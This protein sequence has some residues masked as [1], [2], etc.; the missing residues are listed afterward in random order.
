LLLGHTLTDR[1]E[2]TV[3]NALRGSHISGFVN[4]RAVDTSHGLTVLRPLL[5]QTKLR[6]LQEA[7]MLQIPFFLD[8]TNADPS[9]SARNGVRLLLNQLVE[10]YDHLPT[11]P[12]LYESFQAVYDHLEGE[13]PS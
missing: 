7:Q 8:P 5:R 3:L 11:A 9:V 13:Q 12:K 6:V 1:V 4:M 10:Q 2:T